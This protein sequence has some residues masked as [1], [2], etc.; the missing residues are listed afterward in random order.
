M[1]SKNVYLTSL[2]VGLPLKKGTVFLL[3][4]L[5]NLGFRN[6]APLAIASNGAGP[7]YG[8]PRPINICERNQL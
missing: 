6:T 5:L 4:G 1:E 2:S 3:W 8:K 7:S